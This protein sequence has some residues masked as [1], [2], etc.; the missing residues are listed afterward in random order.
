G[1]GFLTSKIGRSIFFVSLGLLFWSLGTLIFA[2]YN[3]ALGVEVPYP[4]IADVFYVL[5]YVFY[6]LGIFFLMYSTG[7][8]IS[9][10]KS[11]G[12]FLV[13]FVPIVVFL[14][15]GYF[16]LDIG[17]LFS[18]N[19]LS[20]ESILD[21]F[22]PLGDSLLLTFTLLII[23]LSVK[24]LGGKYKFPIYL[25]LLGFIIEYLADLFFSIKTADDT[26]FV[27]GPTDLMFLTSTY[28]VSLS[29]IL[30]DSKRITNGGSA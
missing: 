1:W 3:L 24:Y 17:S 27:G 22:Y 5:L 19:L 13:A 28:L 2:Y 18:R 7:A 6:T 29:L 25:L 14:F 23:F 16:L 21:I 11:H 26:F 9:I 12:K 4:S 20:F 30:F 10:K 8:T 15:S